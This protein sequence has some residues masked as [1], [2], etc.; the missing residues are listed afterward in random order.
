MRGYKLIVYSI[1]CLGVTNYHA[2]YNIV[3]AVIVVVVIVIIVI[4]LVIAVKKM[5]QAKALGTRH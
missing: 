5:Y 3:V 2:T 4:I 1:E